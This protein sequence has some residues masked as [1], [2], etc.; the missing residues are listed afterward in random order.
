VTE[1]SLDTME[2]RSDQSSRGGST[3]RTTVVCPEWTVSVVVKSTAQSWPEA[4]VEVFFDVRSGDFTPQSPSTRMDSP[5]SPTLKVKG[6]G[7]QTYSV[8]GKLFQGAPGW[9]F[10]RKE[11]TVEDG[12]EQA[13]ELT[14]TPDNK[15]TFV[16]QEGEKALDK[17]TLTLGYSQKTLSYVADAKKAP[18]GLPGSGPTT[19]K[20]VDCDGVWE[21]VSVTSA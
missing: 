2:A 18:L 3:N 15:V 8:G 4:I 6:R 10:E 14:A 9:T 16:V 12:Q 1:M 21:F 13:I 5:T 7:K 20:Q 11:V 19:V 17:A